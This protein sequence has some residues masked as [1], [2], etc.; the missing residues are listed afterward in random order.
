MGGKHK[1]CKFTEGCLLIASFGF[2]D[3]SGT[4]FCSK[5]KSNG[6]INLL[7]KLCEC[8]LSRPTYNYPEL[9]ANFCKECKDEGMINSKFFIALICFPSLTTI[10]TI[11]ITIHRFV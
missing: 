9:T 4:Q 10:N 5:H 8:G 6:M 11:H 7:C 3:G 1:K 2:N